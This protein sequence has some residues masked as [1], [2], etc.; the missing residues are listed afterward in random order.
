MPLPTCQRAVL[1]LRVVLDLS[2]S[3]TARLLGISEG[4]VSTT[5]I[6]ARRS[7]A[8]KLTEPRVIVTDRTEGTSA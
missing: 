2:Q 5:L 6:D 1:G 4:T 7:V 3:E 8:R